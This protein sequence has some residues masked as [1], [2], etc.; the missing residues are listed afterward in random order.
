MLATKPRT[1]SSGHT[2]K[3]P[4]GAKSNSTA[5]KR[6]SAPPDDVTS[7]DAGSTRKKKK[8]NLP[9]GIDV[10]MDDVEEGR[11]ELVVRYGKC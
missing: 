7:E 11:E 4:A 1:K 3:L 2:A 6:R 10:G 5:V 8:S 9:A